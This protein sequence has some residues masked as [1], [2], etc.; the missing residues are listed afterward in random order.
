MILVHLGPEPSPRFK[1]AAGRRRLPEYSENP[2]EF[3]RLKHDG[4]SSFRLNDGS[5]CM[6][7]KQLITENKT[8]KTP[9]HRD[10]ILYYS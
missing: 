6:A 4:M 7:K 1:M 3:C 9:F 10:K 5:R 2:A 8:P